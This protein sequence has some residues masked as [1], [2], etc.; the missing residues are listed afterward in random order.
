MTLRGAAEKYVLA[1]AFSAFYAGHCV[2]CTFTLAITF[3]PTPRCS[4][5]PVTPFLSAAL[6]P[7]L[8]Q[9]TVELQSREVIADVARKPGTTDEDA[10][11]YT[12]H[13]TEECFCS[14]KFTTAMALPI[15][16]LATPAFSTNE[17]TWGPKGGGNGK[18]VAAKG[19]QV[20]AAAQRHRRAASAQRHR[21]SASA[22]RSPFCSVGDVAAVVHI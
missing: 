4:P 2:L 20:V 19:E 18:G 3:S 10:S 21:S 5:R 22:P 13:A 14:D 15:P 8:P 16:L 9:I 11:A 12:T 17:G 1:V 7:V 6:L